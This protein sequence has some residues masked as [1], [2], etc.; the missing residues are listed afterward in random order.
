MIQRHPN[1]RGIIH[2]SD[3]LNKSSYS[4]GGELAKQYGR[5]NLR[6]IAQETKYTKIMIDAY[7][8]RKMT[9]GKTKFIE[10]MQRLL[11]VK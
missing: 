2:R 1:E 7:P 5:V 4:H 3:R 8:K 10:D 6:G 9:V 11:D